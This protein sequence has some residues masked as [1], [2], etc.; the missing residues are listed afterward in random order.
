MM[1]EN[2]QK[3]LKK[4]RDIREIIPENYKFRSL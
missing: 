2:V 1:N 3:S 4:K